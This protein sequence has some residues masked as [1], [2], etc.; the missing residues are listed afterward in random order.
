MSFSPTHDLQIRHPELVSGSISPHIRSK[1]WQANA[2]RKVA[3]LGIRFVDQVDFPRSVPALE[4]FFARDG[5]DHVSEHFEMDQ[6]K[7][8]IFGRKPGKCAVPMLPHS[9]KQVRGDANIKRPIVLTSKDVDGRVSLLPHGT[10]LG[11]RWTLKQVQGDGVDRFG[12]R[13]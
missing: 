9:A 13:S 12:D 6:P 11:A 10:E 4:L 1:G 7:D 5:G 3:P 2:H 8:G